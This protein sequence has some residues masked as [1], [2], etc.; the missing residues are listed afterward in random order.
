[1]DMNLD[2]LSC[3]HHIVTGIVPVADAFAGGVSSDVINLKNYGRCT[4]VI[5]TGAIQDGC[6]SN[7]VTVDAC[8][9]AA[10]SNTTA[11]PFYHRSQRWST[12]NDIWAD[13]TP[14]LA[15][16]SGYNFTVNHA[17]A[18]AIHIVDITGEMV[19]QAAPGYEFARLTIAETANKTITAG[20][21]VILSRPRFTQ[22]LPLTAIA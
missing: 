8:D 1:M 9:D 18:N 16:A 7:L 2:F 3:G 14:Q 5:Q 20:V 4:F 13:V 10:A 21:L 12:T 17:V 11:M 6:V 15:T 19:E 22:D